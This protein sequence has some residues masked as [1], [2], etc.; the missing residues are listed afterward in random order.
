ML[1]YVPWGVGGGLSSNRQ[2]QHD[3]FHAKVARSRVGRLVWADP[4]K[5][6]YPNRS[7]QKKMLV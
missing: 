2:S 5:D 4:T 3:S 1:L 6:V 7:S